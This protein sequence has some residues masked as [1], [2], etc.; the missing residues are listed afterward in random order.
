MWR[1]ILLSTLIIA[2]VG[3]ALHFVYEWTGG[4]AV[5]GIFAP[6]NESTWEHLKLAFWPMLLLAPVQRRWYRNPPGWLPATAIR[7]LSAP[8]LIIA[9]FYGYVAILGTHHLPLDIGLFVLSVFGGE[10][11]GHLVM[12]RRCSRGVRAAALTAIVLMVAVFV[13]F[14]VRR[15]PGFLFAPPS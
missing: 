9:L 1:R 10:V 3:T 4:N 15:P 14:S 7:A 8:L 12:E 6:L 2:P 13:A 11:L 5:A